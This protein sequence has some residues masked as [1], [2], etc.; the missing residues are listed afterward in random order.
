MEPLSFE[1]VKRTSL[2][3]RKSKV[4]RQDFGKPV[5]PDASAAHFLESLPNILAGS[6]LRRVARAV[7]NAREKDLPVLWCLGAHVIKVGLNPIL[8][9]LMRQGFVTGLAVN[10][11]CIIHDAEL[12]L[13]GKTSEDVP[14]ALAGKNFGMAEET[15]QI[16]N[17]ATR[18][19]YREKRGLG[20]SVGRLLV[21]QNLPYLE[22]SLLAQAYQLGVPVT[23]HVAIGGDIVHMHPEVSG[24]ALGDASFRDF[25]IFCALVSKVVRDSVILNI[26]SAVMLPVVMEK[27]IAVCRNLGYPVEGFVGVNL[28]F[29]HHYRAHLN[30]VMRARD[31]GGAGYQILGHHEI[32]VPL[33]AAAVKVCAKSGQPVPARKERVSE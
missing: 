32:V 30:P 7:V 25:Q 33:L 13:A 26:G 2:K 6:D 27:A 28:D 29:I 20:E 21:E 10:G 1:H 15:A 4:S 17:E 18:R 12:A 14:E 8:I 5:S 31:L 16:I 11:A 9:D 22:E 23:V 19:A 24:E 3:E